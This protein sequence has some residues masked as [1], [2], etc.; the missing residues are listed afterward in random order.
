MHH[1][2]LFPLFCLEES[3]P[4][5][6]YSVTDMTKMNIDLDYFAGAI[7]AMKAARLNPLE[8]LRAE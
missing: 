6:F 1:S 4:L 2:M 3:I 8:A 5:A 7:P